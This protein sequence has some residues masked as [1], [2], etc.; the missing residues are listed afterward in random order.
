MTKEHNLYLDRDPRNYIKDSEPRAFYWIEYRKTY[1]ALKNSLT[2]GSIIP[3][4]LPVLLIGNNRLNP[5]HFDLKK[6]DREP[7]NGIS[8]PGISAHIGFTDNIHL[9]CGAIFDRDKR[10]QDHLYLIP[11][12][13]QLEEIGYLPIYLPTPNQPLHLR[14]VHQHHLQNPNLHLPPFKA[15]IKLAELF[16]KYKIV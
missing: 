2:I 4:H 6:K 5:F 15:R 13:S 1:F 12:A 14:I 10:R 3:A 7:I 9:A 8:L 11:S 16:S